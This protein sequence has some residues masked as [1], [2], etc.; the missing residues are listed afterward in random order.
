MNGFMRF[1]GMVIDKSCLHMGC[2]GEN[3]ICTVCLSL[4]KTL[5]YRILE[6]VDFQNA[7][8]SKESEKWEEKCIKL[9]PEEN[10]ERK[11]SEDSSGRNVDDLSGRAVEGGT[12]PQKNMEMVIPRNC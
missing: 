9:S 6:G 1:R 5:H 4:E 11:A 12:I 2:F 10:K 7:S 8:V 3:Q